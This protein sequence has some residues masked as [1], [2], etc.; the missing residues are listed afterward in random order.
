MISAKLSALQIVI[1]LCKINS[2]K[3]VIQQNMYLILNPA[4]FGTKIVFLAQRVNKLYM[5][6]KQ[7]E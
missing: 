1:M 5:N 2:L 4:S 3:K 7:M 6:I